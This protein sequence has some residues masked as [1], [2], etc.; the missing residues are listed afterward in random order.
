MGFG[1]NLG[2]ILIVLPLSA[3][4]MILWIINKKSI[5]G[6]TLLGIWGSI[7]LLVIVASITRPLF[8]KIELKKNDFYGD[9][10]VNRDYFK[11]KQADWQYNHFRFE[12][13]SNDSILFYVTEND[14]IIKTFKGT[15][16]TVKPY[17]SARLILK[18]EKPT[19]HIISDNPTIYRSIW[20]FYLVFHSNRFNNVFFEKGNWKPIN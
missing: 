20:S 6:L 4:L 10:V 17:N 12:I 7:I 13:K 9:Y 5:F 15:I 11:G 8:E 3:I 1:F 14:K 19:H 16:A 2:I 18:M